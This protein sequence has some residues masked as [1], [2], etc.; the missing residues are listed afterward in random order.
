MRIPNEAIPSPDPPASRLD[1]TRKTEPVLYAGATG[2]E[3]SHSAK[4]LPE[5]GNDNQVGRS[6]APEADDT[7]SAAASA[8]P[9]EERRQGER[10]SSK[11]PIL[12]DTRRP[13]VHR[14]RTGSARISL[15]I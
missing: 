2:Y 1:E 13:Q 12:L 4:N 5:N 11:K 10:R 8:M 3:L 6:A 14:R 15:K 9:I 7:K